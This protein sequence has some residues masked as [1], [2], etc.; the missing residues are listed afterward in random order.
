MQQNPKTFVVCI[1]CHK[2]CDIE[3]CA[4]MII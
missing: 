4:R 2:I 3:S 1:Y